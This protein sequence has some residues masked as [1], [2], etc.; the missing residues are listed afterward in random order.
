MAESTGRVCWEHGWGNGKIQTSRFSH[1]DHYIL[2][3]QKTQLCFCEN[4]RL[5]ALLNV[6]TAGANLGP[7]FHHLTSLLMQCLSAC[8]FATINH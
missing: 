2:S 1:A 4:G 3:S 5:I 7:R 6:F 8:M